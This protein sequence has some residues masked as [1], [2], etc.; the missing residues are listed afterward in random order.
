MRLADHPSRITGTAPR[1]TRPPR[2]IA[3][4]ALLTA[5]AL[6][7]ATL[8]IVVVVRH[9]ERGRSEGAATSHAYVVAS[10]AADRL[11]PR[12]LAATV[13]GDRLAALD[14]IFA[15]RVLSHGAL[16]VELVAPDGRVTYAT[17]HGR[18]GAAADAPDRVTEALGGSVVSE[19]ATVAGT[20]VGIDVLRAYAAVRV[21][22]GADGVLVIDQDYGPISDATRRAVLPVVAI[23]ELVLIGLWV[24]LFPAL[25]RATRNMR[26]QLDTIRHQATHDALTGL[27]NRR[28][29]SSRLQ[30]ELG[31]VDPSPVTV[32]LLDLD[33]FKQVNDTLGH[34]NGDALLCELTDRL[35]EVTDDGDTIARLGGDEFGVISTRATDADSADALARRFRTALA[36]PC[37]VGGVSVE[38]QVSIGIAFAP[39]HGEDAETLLRR[40]DIAMYAAKPGDVPLVFQADLDDGSPTRLALA[41]ELRQALESRELTVYY[42]PQVDLATGVVKGVEAL[43]RWQHPERGFL[44]PDEFL[45]VAEQAGLMR[46]VTRVVLDESLRQCR[47]WLN[48]GIELSTAVNVSARDLLDTR[49]PD[50]IERT[51]AQHGVEPRLLQIEITE[52]TLMTDA[53]RSWAILDRIAALGVRIAVDDYGV[54]YSSLGQLRNLPVDELKID[55][56]FVKG[57]T[58]QSSDAVIVRSTIDLAHSLGLGVVA[59]GVEDEETLR[60]LAEAGCDLAQGYLLTRPLPAADLTV[61]LAGRAQVPGVSRDELAEVHTLRRA[62]GL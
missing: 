57:M 38:M 61:W 22:G 20:G 14:R 3:R 42:Q 9:F 58:S 15:A 44:S 18:I 51:L 32:M 39:E 25:A 4:F 8:A 16:G 43:V 24:S 34:G 36:R 55:R 7:L 46:S 26:N 56:S 2:L 19:L 59:E 23:L 48:N 41:G 12:D 54:G 50:E 45:P 33:R 53:A 37:E 62:S 28:L 40:A 60:L 1:P 13:T 49:L 27:P 21:G 10:A 31:A 11:L 29:F 47:E 6:A 17:D 5:A 35:L 30:E 52:G